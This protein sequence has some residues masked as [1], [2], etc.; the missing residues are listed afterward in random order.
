M[1]TTGNTILIT[2]GASG[3]GRGLA[4]AF[5]KLGNQVIICGRR[6]AVLEEVTAANPGMASLP[7]D[8]TDCTSINSCVAQAINRFPKLNALINNAGVMQLED[9]KASPA[10]LADAEAMVMT[11]LLG[12]IRMSA[13]ILPHLQRQSRSALLTVTSGLAFVPLTSAPTYC[14]TK[15]AA[16]SYTVSLRQQLQGTSVEV[17]ELAPPYVQ[18]EL[19]GKHQATDPKAMPLADYISETMALLERGETEV[20]V[21]RCKPLRFAA[22]TGRMDEMIR[23]LNSM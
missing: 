14:A 15:A 13:A 5:H 3:I 8:I 21:E 1:K 10:S 23:M 17:I 22:E 6:Q 2:G 4:E 7:L 19:L 18:T 12:T 20:I 11:N 16:H 9:T